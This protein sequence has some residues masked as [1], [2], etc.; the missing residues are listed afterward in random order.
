VGHELKRTGTRRR[1]GALGLTFALALAAAGCQKDSGGGADGGNIDT[2]G[3]DLKGDVVKFGFL[4]G[5]TGAYSEFA[6]AAL[7]GAQLAVADI[8]AAGGVNGGRVELIIQDNKST[9]EG[10]VSGYKKLVEA[11]G[12]SAIGGIDSDAV[13]ALLKPTSEEHMPTICAFCGT[14]ALDRTGGDYMWRFTP[15]DTDVGIATAQYA[16]DNE[17]LAMSAMTQRTEGSLSGLASFLKVFEGPVG[18]ELINDVQFDSTKSTFQ[19][20]VQAAQDGD[21]DAIY[22][23]MGP[24][25]AISMLREWE[26]R[27]NEGEFLMS[28]DLT[29]PEVAKFGF[30]EDRAV[31]LAPAFDRS[32]PAFE[33]FAKQLKEETNTEPNEGLG[34][35]NYYDTFIA[36]GLAA[37]AAGDATPEEINAKIPEI[38]NAPGTVCY[39]YEECVK[40]L[41]AGE[42]I[43][44]HG[45]SG[46]L[47]LNEYG[48]LDRPVMTT[49]EVQDGAWTSTGV[50]ELDPSLRVD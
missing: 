8:N 45:A 36:L 32:T 24:S 48:N 23:S 34:E 14:T 11:D 31:A 5:I 40:L 37:T 35:P 15:S 17:L 29:V 16:R 33:A 18:G 42:D 1:L 3:D 25:Q 12:V 47:D 44:Y 20:E 10:A 9:P 4:N 26:R 39:L 50:I 28:L 13:Q 27:S 21:P 41:E 43:D 30:L 2:G 7:N 38:V 19:S 49:L 46:S 22:L 6:P